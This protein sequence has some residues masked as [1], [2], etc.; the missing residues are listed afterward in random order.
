VPEYK[1]KGVA[2]CPEIDG[3]RAIAVLAVVLYHAGLGPG[4]GLVGVDVFFVISGYLITSLLYRESATTGRID[5]MAFYARRVRRVFPALIVVVL[6]TVV[7]SMVL[8]SPFG[9]KLELARSAAASLIFVGN[10][11]FQA[12]TGGYF[13]SSANL[14]PMLHLWSLSVEEQFYAVWPVLFIAILRFRPRSRIAVIASLAVA[15]LVL[16]EVLILFNPNAAF[17]QMPARFWEL[18]LG[19]VIALLLAG[20]QRDGRSEIIAGAILVLVATAIPIAHFP[21]IGALPAVAGAALVLH[22]VHVSSTLGPMGTWLRSRPMVFCGLISYS[23]YL[24]HWPLLALYRAS[25]VGPP[26]LPARASLVASAIVLAWFSYRF[27]ERPWRRP[28]P[29]TTDSGLVASGLIMSASLAFLVMKVGVLFHQQPLPDDLVSRTSRDMPENR[30]A[31]NYRGDE[32]LEVFPKPGCNSMPDKPVRVV[33][34]GDSHALAWQPMA[35][36]IA[37]RNGVA[38]TSYTRD[39]CPPVLD[40]D[41]GK[42][43]QEAN[44]CRDFN[45]RVF[46]KVKV[47]NIDTLILTALWPDDLTGNNFKG[48][49]ESTMQ[50]LVPQVRRIV[51]LGPTPYLHDSAP[52]CIESGNLDACAVSRSGFEVRYGAS[53]QFLAALAAKYDNAEYVDLTDF[54]C[55]QETCPVLKDGYALYWDSNHV[56][57]TA[58]RHFSARYLVEKRS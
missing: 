1:S 15:S 44:R 35:W 36:A 54:F 2:Y 19:G 5:L 46:N 43:L 26:T 30:V 6:S 52:R 3:L 39:A 31:C 34:W 4:A 55:D 29:R 12:N 18:A 57:S 58:A 45:V 50:R 10:L 7:V 17:Y 24:W 22:A 28:D 8:L 38:A 9:E 47:G 42:R 11:F 25:H 37:Q 40:Y 33:I 16:A 48:K 49:F 32:G 56:S 51:L 20:Q 53:R 41:N 13:D 27:V 14:L 21:G 23:L